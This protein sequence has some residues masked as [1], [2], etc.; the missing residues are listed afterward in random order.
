MLVRGI[1]RAGRDGVRVVRRYVLI[2]KRYRARLVVCTSV[3]K[4]DCELG[5]DQGQRLSDFYD[6]GREAA[7]SSCYRT[8]ET[9]AIAHQ[10]Y[11]RCFGGLKVIHPSS[12][13]KH[14]QPAVRCARAAD[15]PATVALRN[16][17]CPWTTECW[18]RED[19]A[20]AMLYSTP[21]SERTPYT[22]CSVDAI[23]ILVSCPSKHVHTSER[24]ALKG[25]CGL[26][27]HSRSQLPPPTTSICSTSTSSRQAH[28][29]RAHTPTRVPQ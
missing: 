2:G 22:V 24:L 20:R 7:Q 16:P 28:E 19:G 6:C 5:R 21:Q 29:S 8:R 12:S 14:P 3:V 1:R 25:A 10:H 11:R 23:G 17:H 27:S 15:G 9:F 13:C 18:A 26:P 4:T